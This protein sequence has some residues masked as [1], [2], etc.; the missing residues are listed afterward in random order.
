MSFFTRCSHIEVSYL[1]LK[2]PHHNSDLQDVAKRPVDLHG[3]NLAGWKSQT[4]R[5]EDGHWIYGP[6][7]LD[8][9]VWGTEREK[10]VGNRA[11]DLSSLTWCRNNESFVQKQLYI[12]GKKILSLN[13][14]TR[15]NYWLVLSPNNRTTSSV[16]SATFGVGP[17]ASLL[18]MPPYTHVCWVSIF[19]GS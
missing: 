4:G 12:W 13:W 15:R 3:Y 18:A 16:L 10:C 2:R 11:G 17:P 14:Q 7:R 5:C 6:N 1:R 19:S 8:T 9:L